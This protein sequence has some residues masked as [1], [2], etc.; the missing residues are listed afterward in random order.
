MAGRE[1]WRIEHE[2]IGRRNVQMQKEEYARHDAY[3]NEDERDRI[4]NGKW[5]GW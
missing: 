1:I 3:A 5:R 2:N 4:Q